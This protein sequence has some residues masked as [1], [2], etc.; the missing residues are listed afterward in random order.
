MNQSWGL[1]CRLNALVIRQPV[2]K[3]TE[4][5][6]LNAPSLHVKMIFLL[7]CNAINTSR[8]ISSSLIY[9]CRVMIHEDMG[10]C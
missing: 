7:P 5:L 4:N 2:L 10:S 9:R 1:G 3:Q 6:T 8:T